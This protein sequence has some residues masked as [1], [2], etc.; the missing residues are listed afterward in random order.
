MEAESFENEHIAEILNSHFVPIKVDRE[1]RPDLDEV[2]MTAVQTVAGAGGWP[3]SVFLTPQQKP[4][5]GGTYFPVHDIFGRPGFETVLLSIADAWANRR[6]EVINSAENVTKI[7]SKSASQE[8]AQLQPFI[9]DEAYLHLENNF[10][11]EYGG[12]GSAPK[13]PNPCYLSFLLYLLAPDEKRKSPA[14]GHK[15]TR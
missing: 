1:E 5:Y 15:N 11:A 6:E 9:F 3:L 4:F 2:Y 10:D 7:I 14:D 13:F 8:T 12:F